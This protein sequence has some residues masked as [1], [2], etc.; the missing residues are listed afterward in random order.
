M[1]GNEKTPLTKSIIFYDWSN[2]KKE[3]FLISGEKKSEVQRKIF[4]QL[5]NKLLTNIIKNKF[6]TQK[7]KAAKS[8][9]VLIVIYTKL[10]TKIK[11]IRK[12]N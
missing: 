2:K 11:F 1:R 7:L 5:K 10:D 6:K 9:V 4:T 12:F 3:N 8:I